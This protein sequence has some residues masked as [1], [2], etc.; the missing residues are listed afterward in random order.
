MA[1]RLAV[2]HGEKLRPLLVS[3][4]R[5]RWKEEIILYGGEST[6]ATQSVI[7]HVHTLGK[8]SVPDGGARVLEV[9]S[10]CGWV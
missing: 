8:R 2:K 10:N 3:R 7:C 1:A 4:R 6:G 5:R 9:I